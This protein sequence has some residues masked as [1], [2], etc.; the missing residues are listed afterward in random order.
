[1]IDSF[2]DDTIKFYTKYRKHGKDHNGNE[3]EINL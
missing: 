2:D 1:M 3:Q